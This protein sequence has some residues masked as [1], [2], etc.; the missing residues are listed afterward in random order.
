MRDKYN[1]NKKEFFLEILLIYPLYSF[2][3]FMKYL[4]E[5]KTIYYLNPYYVLMSDNIFYIIKKIIKLTYN[6]KD[7]K[8]YLR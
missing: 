7:T 8:T 3:G 4:F 5:T 2:V 1:E 6:P